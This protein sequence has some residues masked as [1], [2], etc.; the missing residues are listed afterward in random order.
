MDGPTNALLA[1]ASL[2]YLELLMP[3]QG[4]PKRE[5]HALTMVI[6]EVPHIINRIVQVV[7]DTE[8][9]GLGHYSDPP[10]LDGIVQVGIAWRG[11]NGT[12]LSEQ[13]DCNP[14]A[15]CLSNGRASEAI[16]VHGLREVDVARFPPAD[17][18]AE[19]LR[20]K[21]AA[22]A[23]EPN[24]RIVLRAYN[25]GFDKPFLVSP[26][27]S[28]AEDRW[29]D[30]IM[31]EARVAIGGPDGRRLKLTL[32]SE[33][34]KIS[35]PSGKPHSAGYDAKLALLVAETLASPPWSKARVPL[36]S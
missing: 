24:S 6:E 31:E 4:A 33:V 25:V 13:Y 5:S 18:V 1:D 29:G 3:H 36:S 20:T 2:R 27:W 14:G 8:T 23:R 15:E 28:L 30:C 16:R 9:T 11:S 21:L 19:I 7:I 32:A 35:L 22:I 34:L 12:M 26:P 10:R 17:K